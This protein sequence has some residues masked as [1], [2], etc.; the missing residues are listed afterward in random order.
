VARNRREYP[1]KKSPTKPIILSVRMHPKFKEF[2]ASDS[3][4][5]DKDPL[6]LAVPKKGIVSRGGI[7]GGGESE[8]GIE[9]EDLRFFGGL[10]GW[11]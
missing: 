7:E 2:V 6:I 9:A 5:I 1:F 4:F 10:F 3:N 8:G 11:V